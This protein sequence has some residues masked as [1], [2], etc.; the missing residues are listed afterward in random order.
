MYTEYESTPAEPESRLWKAVLW[1]AFDDLFYRGLEHTLIVAKSE[2]RKWF[3][4]GSW[5]FQHVCLFADYNP[6]YVSDKFY[7]LK[8]RREYEFTQPQI[9]YLK[10]RQKYLNDNRRRQQ[11]L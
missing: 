9:L 6:Q 3:L 2:S 11:R 7:E 1:R 5:D 10:Q 4:G 8:N